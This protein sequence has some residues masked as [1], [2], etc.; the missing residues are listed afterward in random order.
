MRGVALLLLAAACSVHGRRATAAHYFAGQLKSQRLSLTTAA[1]EDPSSTERRLSGLEALASLLTLEN[2]MAGW[3]VTGHPCVHRF[4]RPSDKWQKSRRA[5]LHGERHT[6]RMSAASKVRKPR[7][8]EEITQNFRLPVWPAWY[9]IFWIILDLFGQKKLAADLEEK[10]GGRVCP[11]ML[12]KKRSDPFIL[13][14][15]HRHS[16]LRFDPFRPIFRF[17]LPE[18]FPAHGHRG[19]ETLTYVLPG[20]RGLVHRDSIGL[21]MTYGDGEC[22]WMT[23]GR[24]MLHEEMWSND[25]TDSSPEGFWL[26]S[27]L[28]QIWLNLP[29]KHKMTEPRIQLLR[30]SQQQ[31]EASPPPDGVRLV[32]L[33]TVSPSA[34]VTVR[35]L[36]GQVGGISS[37]V[38]TFS[39]VSVMH[40][41]IEPGCT[42]ELP[43][44]PDFTAMLYV[45]KGN[46][47]ASLGKPIAI[48]DLVYFERS[49]LVYSGTTKPDGISVTNQ[50]EDPA[51]TSDVLLL[52]GRPLREPVVAAGP[53][54]VNSQ[55][56]Y[57]QAQ[58][59]FSMDPAKQPWDHELSDE[60]WKKFVTSEKKVKVPLRRFK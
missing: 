54:V 53:F 34:G 45:R 50:A 55:E 9:G 48:H 59:E 30:P 49:D 7:N 28:Y 31:S 44:P 36:A 13:A 11:M 20:R 56:E 2:S 17:L 33:P 6:A 32:E 1:R 15:H 57:Y 5:V 52:A 12:D 29:A 42:W 25:R 14:V 26:D 35:V 41:T 38:E 58:R 39:D 4:C 22:Q 37:K 21:K 19:F 10:F 16:W 18:G 24:G 43:L 3:E 40:T 23:A 27:E 47:L 8:I 51:D 60:D 46:S